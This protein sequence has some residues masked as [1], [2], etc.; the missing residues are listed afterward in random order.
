MAAPIIGLVLQRR[1]PDAEGGK[2]VEKL[3]GGQQALA[4]SQKGCLEGTPSAFFA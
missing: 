4:G 3:L 1:G 2:V